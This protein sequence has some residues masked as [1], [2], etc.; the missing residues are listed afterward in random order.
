MDALF[1]GKKRFKLRN[2]KGEVVHERISKSLDWTAKVVCADCN[3]TWMSAIENDHAKP[4]M[5]D[6]ISG[7]VDIPIDE[8]RAQSIALFAF[9]TAVVFDHMQRNQEPFFPGTIRHRF[10]ESIAIPPTTVKMWMAGYLPTAKGEVLTFYSQGNLT[11]TNRLRLYV[12]TYAVGH[13]VFQVVAQRQQGF[14]PLGPAADY[15]GMA[16]PFWPTSEL[17]KG[18]IWPPKAILRTVKD[19]SDFSERWR[20]INVPQRF[21]KN[22]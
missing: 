1:P 20:T 11:P 22:C 5:T 3:N 16:I 4:A 21:L 9:K 18:F 14:I 8:A 12:C 10:R 13:F 7:K 17:P 6:L 2:E 15:S 19:F